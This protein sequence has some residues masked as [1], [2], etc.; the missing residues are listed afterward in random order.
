MIIPISL[1]FI[2]VMLVFGV[3][4]GKIIF[5]AVG[6]VLIIAGIVIGIILLKKLIDKLADWFDEWV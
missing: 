2:L 6:P 5:E 4:L 3:A 1:G